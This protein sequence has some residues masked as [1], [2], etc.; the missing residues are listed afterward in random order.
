MTVIQA[1]S[2]RSCIMDT[3]TWNILRIRE[4]QNLQPHELHSLAFKE[5]EQ[6][7]TMNSKQLLATVTANRIT[8]MLLP[9]SEPESR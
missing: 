5:V 3:V 6:L 1:D 9:T 8:R 7:D 4:L 2:V